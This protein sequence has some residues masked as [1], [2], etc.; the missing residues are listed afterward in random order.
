VKKSELLT[1]MRQHKLAVEASVS[2]AGAP[3]CAVIGIAV[4]E[5]LEVVFDT[6]STSR[7]CANLRRDPRL[8]LVLGWDLDQAC[9]VQLEGL[10]DEPRGPELEHLKQL[11]FSVFPDGVE[12]AAWPDITYVR[13]KPTFIRFSDFRGAAPKI[14]ELAGAEL[15]ALR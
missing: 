13:M 6:L 11:Y 4:S 14:V 15:I 2:A 3:Q 10:A 7:K 1:F 5:E 9:T 8:A 12:R